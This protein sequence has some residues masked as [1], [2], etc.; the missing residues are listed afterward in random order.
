MKRLDGLRVKLFADGADLDGILKTGVVRRPDERGA[1]GNR[2]R[3]GAGLGQ[4]WFAESRCVGVQIVG[5]MGTEPSGR[6]SR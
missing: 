6:R 2:W 5:V 3:C 1:G 4:G